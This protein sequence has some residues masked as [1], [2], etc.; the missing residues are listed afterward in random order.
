MPP[1]PDIVIVG[2]G[3]GGATVAAGLAATGASILILERG[4]GR[5]VVPM[6]LTRRGPHSV[7]RLPCTWTDAMVC[8]GRCSKEALRSRHPH[9]DTV[10]PSHRH[11]DGLFH[12]SSCRR[13]DA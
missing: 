12:R 7:Q 5:R 8:E 3:M 1:S 2:S 11:D 9:P 4:S 10:I 13:Q 6:A